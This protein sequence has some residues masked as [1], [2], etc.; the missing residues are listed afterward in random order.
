M[1]PELQE[2]YH[3]HRILELLCAIDSDAQQL[4]AWHVHIWEKTTLFC[5]SEYLFDAGEVAR[6]LGGGECL[7][8]VSEVFLQSLTFFRY[9]HNSGAKEELNLFK[10]DVTQTIVPVE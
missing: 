4:L 3:D 5:L 9:A 2:S 10:S 8:F 6:E 7:G 1:A